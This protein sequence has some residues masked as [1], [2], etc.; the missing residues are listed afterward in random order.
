[1]G[2]DHLAAMV[3][4]GLWA[5]QVGGPGLWMVPLTFVS[6]MAIGGMLG[7]A[8]LPVPSVEPGILASL[9][10]LGQLVAAAVGM[11][12]LAS[13]LLVGAIALYHGYVHGMEM[14]WIAR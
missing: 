12:R 8:S 4:V 10:V 7:V 2:I 6:L 11:P 9:R 3:V 5:A 13:C 1:M 14:G